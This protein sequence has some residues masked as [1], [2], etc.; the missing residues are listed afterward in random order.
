MPPAPVLVR[1]P[2]SHHPGIRL[3]LIPGFRDPG[4][5]LILGQVTQY[6]NPYLICITV[7]N[8]H[9]LSPASYQVICTYTQ[10]CY[11]TFVWKFGYFLSYITRDIFIPYLWALVIFS[12]RYEW[13]FYSAIADLYALPWQCYNET[14]LLFYGHIIDVVQGCN[15]KSIS[16]Q[17]LTI[18]T[19]YL[20]HEGEVRGQCSALCNIMLYWTTS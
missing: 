19:W 8:V 20:T 4:S 14:W 18:G 13:N 11:L 15:N 5:V 10:H 2:G 1:I 6:G 12:S 7:N 3:R 9:I 17:M 16:P